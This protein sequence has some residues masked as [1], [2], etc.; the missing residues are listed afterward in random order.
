RTQ[1]QRILALKRFKSGEVLAKTGVAGGFSILNVRVDL[2][3]GHVGVL[4][5]SVQDSPGRPSGTKLL[6]EFVRAQPWLGSRRFGGAAAIPLRR[7]YARLG[8]P[9]LALLGDAGCM[10]FSAHG[11]G[12]AVGLRAARMLSDA[13]SAHSLDPGSERATWSYASRW[14]QDSGG[15]LLAYDVV[16]RVT[17]QMSR[18]DLEQLMSSGLLSSASARAALA[19]QVPPLGALDVISAVRAAIRNPRLAARMARGASSVPGCLAHGK[20]YPVDPDL[21]ALAE[22]ERRGAELAADPVGP[23]D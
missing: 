18:D 11:S 9:G 8:A 19:Q 17:Q 2:H 4:T 20:R 14:H 21:R 5:G 16:R 3:D 12:I 10:N 15:L 13:V 1:G 6:E 23:V 22:Y 7:P